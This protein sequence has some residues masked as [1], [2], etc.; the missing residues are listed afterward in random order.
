MSIQKIDR[1]KTSQ[2]LKI[3][4]DWLKNYQVLN[5]VDTNDENVLLDKDEE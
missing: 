2:L 5:Q 4:E 1:K 3:L